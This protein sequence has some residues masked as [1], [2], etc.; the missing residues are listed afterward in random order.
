MPG[1][2]PRPLIAALAIALAAIASGCAT[3]TDSNNVARVE[4]RTLSLDELSALVSIEFNVPQGDEGS[5]VPGNAEAARQAMTNWIVGQVAAIELAELDRGVSTDEIEQIEAQL[6]EALPDISETGR[7]AYAETSAA[8]S[9]FGQLPQPI[10]FFIA[11]ASD[12]DIYV[13]PRFGTFNP[14]DG[15]TPLR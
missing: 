13:D 7:A 8:I 11:A 14:V 3:F 4:D 2:T 10:E 5:N 15:V 9:A 1:V 6:A 12:T